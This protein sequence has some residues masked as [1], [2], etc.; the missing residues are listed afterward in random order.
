MPSVAPTCLLCLPDPPTQHHDHSTTP[1]FHLSPRLL[2]ARANSGGWAT[3]RNG[4][5]SSPGWWRRPWGS[6]SSRWPAA[7][8]ASAR[9][10]VVAVVVVCFFFL[11]PLLL[12]MISPTCAAE[13]RADECP[14]CNPYTHQHPIQAST[15]IHLAHIHTHQQPTNSLTRLP[16]GL[17]DGDGGGADVRRGGARAAGKP[18]ERRDR[19]L[20]DA[21]QLVSQGRG[22]RC[23]ICLV[24]V[25]LLWGS[26][27]S[28]YVEEE[29]DRCWIIDAVQLV[30]ER[31]SV[32]D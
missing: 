31:G 23:W 21:V 5:R 6:A 25:L 16:L 20:I 14:R 19:C 24:L 3:G 11:L 18:R 22:D 4:T 9:S 15:H 8:R 1:S 27:G 7:V 10:V 12:M 32:L 26:M 13:R 28:W 2:G 29:R 17:R 30:G